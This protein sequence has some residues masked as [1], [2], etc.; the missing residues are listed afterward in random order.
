MPD[1][2]DPASRL[3]AYRIKKLRTDTY[4]WTLQELAANIAALG[5]WA[6]SV[7]QL[8][9]IERCQRAVSIPELSAIAEAI[10]SSVEY[11]TAKGSIC[12]ACGQETPK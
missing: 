4:A 2:T 6:P 10:G 9:L 5:G 8:S 11:F 7:S 3:I 1:I 12:E